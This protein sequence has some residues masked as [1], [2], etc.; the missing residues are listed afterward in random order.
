MLWADSVFGQRF[1]GLKQ[2]FPQH[3]VGDMV[4]DVDDGS[5]GLV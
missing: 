2:L 4:L 3:V 1:L 5:G